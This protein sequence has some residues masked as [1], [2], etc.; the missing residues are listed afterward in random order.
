MREY[1]FKK[2]LSNPRIYVYSDITYQDWLKVGYTTRSVVDRVKEQYPTKR[3]GKN[4]WKIELDVS[5]VKEDGTTFLD[6]EVLKL[7][8]KSG[9]QR[10]DEWVKCKLKSIEVAINSIKDN[11]TFDLKRNLNFKLRVEQKLAIEKAINYFKSYK[12]D[13]NKKPPHFLWNAKMRFGKTFAAYKLAEK[14]NWK[15][16]LIL[17]F[18][19]AVQSAWE[20]DVVS[21]VDFEGWQFLTNKDVFPK[22]ISK[23]IIYFGSFQDFLGK[24]KA[25][26]IKSKNKYVHTVNWDC[27]IFDEYHYGAW[28]ESA[29]ELFD[30][31]DKKE[32]K[33]QLGE[34][35]DYFKEEYLPITTNHYLYLSGTPFRAIASG[36]FIEEQIYNW[37][38]TDEQKLKNNY[39]GDINPYEA[40]PKMVLLTYDLPDSIKSV[41]SKG[42]FD[43]FDLNIFFSTKKE[44]NKSVFVYKNEVQRWLNFIRGYELS[45]IIDDLKQKNDKAILPYRDTLLLNS[46]SHTLWFLPRINSCFAMK[47]LLEE[48]QNNFFHDHKI[49]CAAGNKAGIGIKALEPVRNA[50]QDPFNTKSIT[51]TCGK[52]LTG[53][54]VKPWSAIFMLRNLSSPET[55]FQAAFRTQSSWEIFNPDNKSPNKNEVIKKTCYV[56]DFAPNRALKQVA[57]YSCRL[58]SKEDNP[59]KKVDEFIKFLPI[60][61]YEGLSMKQLNAEG[62]LDMSMSGTTATLLARRWESAL[63]VN[64]DDETLSRILKNEKAMKALMKIEGFRNLNKDVETIL[65]KSENIKKMKKDANK[66]DLDNNEK[67]KLTEEEKEY[68]SLRDKVQK[69]LIKFATRIP[70]FMYLT[71]YRERSLEDIILKLEPN[72]FTKVTGLNIQEFELLVSLN[73]FNREKMNDAVYKFKR[74]EDASLSY[75]GINKH[76]DQPIGLYDTTIENF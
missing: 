41:A 32:M 71:D 15:K 12:E 29:K 2:T 21:H 7:L 53:V 76:K 34:G 5:A 24:N 13:K 35:I 50:M 30:E 36:E 47:N 40:M 61:A 54:T 9:Y 33:D 28:R 16:I 57:D 56:F 67:K 26:G 22:R 66:K 60:L 17:T 23:P 44:A 37:T 55:Y 27:V 38:Y 65:N 3:P 68:K 1:F 46:L 25:G 6:K 39:K 73:V 10:K 64:V 59:E 51:L 48:K 43:Q 75:T 45:S 70:V 31:E 11:K 18:K 14:M 8:E 20:D 49:V 62:I 52:L 63:L 72:L 42:E 74:Y 69:K 19:P 4:P 58:N